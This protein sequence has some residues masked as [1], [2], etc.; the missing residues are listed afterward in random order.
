MVDRVLNIQNLG[1][2]TCQNSEYG[3]ALNMGD[4]EYASVT[5]GSDYVSIS[6][7]RVPNIFRILNMPGF[8]VWHGSIYSRVTQGSK[9]AQ[10]LNMLRHSYNNIVIIVTN[11]GNVSITIL[12]YSIYTSRLSAAN[13]FIFLAR[14]RT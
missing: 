5:Q 4:S 1:S 11:I 12:A 13:H 10:V 14:V 9:Y 6:L 3:K 8:W 7:N 2:E